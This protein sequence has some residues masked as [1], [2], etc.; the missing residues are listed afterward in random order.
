V[1][2]PAYAHAQQR[3]SRLWAG[4]DL[5]HLVD[6][7]PPVEPEQIPVGEAEDSDWGAFVEAQGARR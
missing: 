3:S 6:E 7:V 2:R 1:N 4:D 5:F